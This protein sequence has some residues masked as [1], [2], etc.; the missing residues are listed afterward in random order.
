M[1]KDDLWFAQFNLSTHDRNH[2]FSCWFETTVDENDQLDG[3]VLANALG[4]HFEGTIEQLLSSESRFEGVR[5]YKKRG[6]SAS[7]GQYFV[8][9]GIGL[10]SADALPIN[11]QMRFNFQ[12]D[13][14]D[15][16][17]NNS[18]SISGLSATNQVG[19]DWNG[20]ILNTARTVVVPK[21]LEEIAEEGG[22]GRY[23]IINIGRRLPLNP[24]G[25]PAEVSKI[26]V[27][28]RIMSM[29]PR[30]TRVDGTS[31]VLG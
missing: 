23:R 19:S 21:F 22:P 13:V 24:P 27:N 29:R 4:K 9:D 20:P 7:S 11:N 5:C 30:T 14:Y 12:Q 25:D 18:L 28:S 26:R 3:N 16:R 10:Q 31:A 8:E 6:V 15:A 2:G 1:A 17:Y